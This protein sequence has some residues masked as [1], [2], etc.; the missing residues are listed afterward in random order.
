MHSTPG[1]TIKEANRLYRS[2][3]ETAVNEMDDE[4]LHGFIDHMQIHFGQLHT[5]IAET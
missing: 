5:I 1:T 3:K 4:V 2:L